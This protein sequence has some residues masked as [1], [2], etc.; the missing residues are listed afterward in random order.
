MLRQINNFESDKEMLLRAEAQNFNQLL[1]GEDKGW[2][3]TL[4]EKKSCTTA[5]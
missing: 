5:P 4:R 2:E 1:Q 3:I